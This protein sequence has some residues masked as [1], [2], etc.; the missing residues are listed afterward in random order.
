[1]CCLGAQAHT[2]PLSDQRMKLSFASAPK[3]GFIPLVQANTVVRIADGPQLKRAGNQMKVTRVKAIGN[4]DPAVEAPY[5][6]V[7][8]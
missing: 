5:P 2:S 7:K 8:A 3:L 6:M 1:M 4:V